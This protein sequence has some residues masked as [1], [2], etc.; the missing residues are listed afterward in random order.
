MF[1]AGC[2]ASPPPAPQLT[3]SPGPAPAVSVPDPVARC[4]VWAREVSFAKSVADHDHAAF[5]EHVHENAVFL[6]GEGTT[7]GREA[8]RANWKPIVE[9]QRFRLAWHP[10]EVTLTGDGSIALSRGPYLFED[11]RPEAKQKFRSGTFQSIWQRDAAGVWH[12]TVDGGTPPP[13]PISDEDAAKLE[14]SMKKECPK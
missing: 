13:A 5:A 1:V 7:K 14:A 9:G 8:V 6:D 3:Q 11:K 12:V 10:A 2:A 4:A